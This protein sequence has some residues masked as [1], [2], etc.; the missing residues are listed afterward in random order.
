MFDSSFAHLAFLS[1]TMRSS[2][3]LFARKWCSRCTICNFFDCWW[4][5]F[6]ICAIC[7]PFPG[8]STELVLPLIWQDSC[9]H[10]LGFFYFYFLLFLFFSFSFFS[11]ANC[12]AKESAAFSPCSLSWT[13][14]GT[15]GRGAKAE[16]KIK[17]GRAT[18][19]PLPKGAGPRSGHPLR[20]GPEFEPFRKGRT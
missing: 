18:Q 12:P 5:L 15:P 14:N 19:R 9:E 20:F 6:S 17:G 16:R 1:R 10:R 8:S 13:I 7:A 2:G 11:L 3:F 4:A